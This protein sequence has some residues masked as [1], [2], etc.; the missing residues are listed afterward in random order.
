VDEFYRYCARLTKFTWEAV[1]TRGW[2]KVNRQPVPVGRPGYEDSLEKVLVSILDITERR[3]AQAL[4]EA[5]YRIASAAE[6]PTPWKNFTRTSTG[7]RLGHAGEN[8]ISPF[9]MKTKA[10]ALPLL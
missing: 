10:A 1:T 6:R 5:V 2:R 4:Q 8:S 7:D 3:Q 9:T